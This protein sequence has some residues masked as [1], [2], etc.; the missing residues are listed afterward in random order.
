VSA[1]QEAS[2]N[3]RWESRSCNSLSSPAL[4][5][6]EERRAERLDREAEERS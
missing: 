3:P 1:N 6:E 4:E 5:D 2:V